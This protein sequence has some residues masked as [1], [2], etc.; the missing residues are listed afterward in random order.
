MKICKKLKVAILPIV[1]ILLTSQSAMA[2]Q[3]ELSVMLLGSGGP[4]ATSSGRASAAYMIFT[5]GNPRVLMD[6]GGGS[7]QRL[8]QSGYNI[9]AMEYILCKSYSSGSHR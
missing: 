4:V 1:S 6:V 9:N 7:F 8:A 3:D 2:A 5:D